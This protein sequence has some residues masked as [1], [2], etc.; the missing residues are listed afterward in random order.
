VARG[1]RGNAPGFRL[2]LRHLRRRA[3]PD[4]EALE[5]RGRGRRR[6]LGRGWRS[7]GVRLGKRREQHCAETAQTRS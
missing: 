7:R 4:D 1:E 2:V 5:A 6:R 3:Q